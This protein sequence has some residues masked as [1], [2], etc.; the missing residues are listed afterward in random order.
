M[1]L[2]VTL[3]ACTAVLFTHPQGSMVDAFLP[4]EML[5]LLPLLLL[6]RSLLLLLLLLLMLGLLLLLPHDEVY[7]T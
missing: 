4:R 5:A 2:V 6:L 1:H 3:S 7:E